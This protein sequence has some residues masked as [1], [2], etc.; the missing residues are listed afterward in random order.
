MGHLWKRNGVYYMGY[1]DR[2]GQWKQ[3]SCRTTD[4]QAAKD[5]LR[6]K[7]RNLAKGEDKRLADFLREYLRDRAG[8]HPLTVT[9]Y[10]NCLDALTYE[11]SPLAEVTLQGLDSAAVDDYIAWRLGHG[12][13]RD[14]VKKEV[15][16]LKQALDRA[17]RKKLLSFESAYLIKTDKRPELKKRKRE[18]YLLLPKEWEDMYAAAPPLL[19]DVMVVAFWTGLRQGN[20][21]ALR[22]R[23]FTLGDPAC[24]TFRQDEMKGEYT[25]LTVLLPERV[26]AVLLARW[27]GPLNPDRKLF[28]DFRAKWERF[29]K[30]HAPRGF[31]FH[32]F[33][34]NYI[35]YRIA[36]GVDPKTVQDEVG[37][38]TSSMTMDQYA[39]VLRNPAARAWAKKNFSFPWDATHVQDEA[40]K[41]APQDAKENAHSELHG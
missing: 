30:K 29:K 5:I 6:D 36:A 40:P 7:E 35:S 27:S 19:R 31:R 4:K 21:T 16:F 37:H 23:H 28:E 11:Y 12:R 24:L 38:S 22:E 25:G 1:K 34:G 33:R 18:T 17:V 9:R 13:D 3:E 20:M 39:R 15:S 41:N 32:D 14:T 10:T 8:L 26:K 2:R